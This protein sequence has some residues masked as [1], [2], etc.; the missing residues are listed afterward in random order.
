MPLV[1]VRFAS[2]SGKI[3]R[4][5]DRGEAPVGLPGDRAQAAASLAAWEGKYQIIRKNPPLTTAGKLTS[6]GSIR[7]HRWKCYLDFPFLQ[8]QY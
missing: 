4:S 5:R 1:F 8:S 7:K 3:N 6:I 2:I